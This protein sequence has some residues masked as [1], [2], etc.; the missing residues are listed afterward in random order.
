M[1]VRPSSLCGPSDSTWTSLGAGGDYWGQQALQASLLKLFQKYWKLYY[2]QRLRSNGQMAKTSQLEI[3]DVVLISDVADNSG[4]SNP[5]AALE[6]VI[7]FLH[8]D[9]RSEAIVKYH[10]GTVNRPTGKLVRLIKKSEQVPTQGFLFDNMVITDRE[11][12]K[13]LQYQDP[14]NHITNMRLWA[15][16][17]E[18]DPVDPDLQLEPLAARATQ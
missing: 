11:I 7:G 13:D 2:A 14:D 8:P 10:Q 1:M 6:R 4:R 9:T 5:H 16:R 12:Q 17:G 3:Q 15:P 18:N